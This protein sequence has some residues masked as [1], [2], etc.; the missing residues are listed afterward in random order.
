MTATDLLLVNTTKMSG[1]GRTYRCKQ[2]DETF[3]NRYDKQLDR[4]V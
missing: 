1:S 2:C 3:A 4:L